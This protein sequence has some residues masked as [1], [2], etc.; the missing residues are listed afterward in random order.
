[1]QMFLCACVCTWGWFCICVIARGGGELLDPT[2]EDQAADLL[3]FD[4]LLLSKTS[5]LDFNLKK[6]AKPV[7]HFALYPF[8]TSATE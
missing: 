2:S 7:L 5:F 1:M 8:S 4:L 3:A 6:M